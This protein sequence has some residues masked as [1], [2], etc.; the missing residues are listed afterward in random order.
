MSREEVRGGV[1]VVQSQNVKEFAGSQ[2]VTVLSIGTGSAQLLNSVANFHLINSS[3][4]NLPTFDAILD[5]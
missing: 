2:R 4:E 5:S 1:D 3:C